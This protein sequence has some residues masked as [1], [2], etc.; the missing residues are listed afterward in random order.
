MSSVRRLTSV[1]LGALL[2]SL[3]EIQNKQVK[4]GWLDGARYQDGTPVAYVATIHEFGSPQNGIPPRPFV[5][6]TIS[7]R[8]GEW[9]ELVA[10]GAQGMINGN[11]SANDVLVGLGLQVEGDIRL[12]ISEI[13]SPPLKESTIAAKRNK[14]ADSETTGSLDKPLVETGLMIG[15]LSS[16]VE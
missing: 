3:S 6:P 8:Q 16:E 4:V 12:K 7:E 15:S 2:N 14:L 5:R 10:S 1:N 9:K 11:A 13:Q